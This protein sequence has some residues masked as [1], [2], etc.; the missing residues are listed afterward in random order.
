MYVLGRSSV[1]RQNAPF[2]R[3]AELGKHFGDGKLRFSVGK[4]MEGWDFSR[5]QFLYKGCPWAML[6]VG[7]EASIF[8]SR[9]DCRELP[10]GL[11]RD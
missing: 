8:W 5:L 3:V 6:G 7:K 10:Q 11:R 9:G 2:R 1:V 4:K